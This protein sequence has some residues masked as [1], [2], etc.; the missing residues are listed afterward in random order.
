MSVRLI[1]ETPSA[2]GFPLLIKNIL[3]TPL[4]YYP[5]REIVYRDQMSYT[6]VELNQRIQR[7]ANTLEKMGVKQGDTVA[8]MDWDS[9][10]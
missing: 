9:Y 8:V 3:R 10:R 2:Y 4:T 5:D 7:L 6:Y 1:P